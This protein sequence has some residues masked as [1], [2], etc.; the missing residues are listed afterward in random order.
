DRIV[1]PDPRRRQLRDAKKYQRFEVIGEHGLERRRRARGAAGCEPEE[2]GT[3]LLESRRGKESRAILGEIVEALQG[4]RETALAQREVWKSE[5]RDGPTGR[6]AC[7]DIPAQRAQHIDAD[8][9]A[10]H[11]RVIVKKL[12]AVELV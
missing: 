5:R 7:R 4:V 2:V 3:D 9:G 12:M 11:R 1:A 6:A 10:V 8:A